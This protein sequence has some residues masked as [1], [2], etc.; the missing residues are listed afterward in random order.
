MLENFAVR[1]GARK[2]MLSS[3]WLSINALPKLKTA[4]VKAEGSFGLSGN[5]TAEMFN[6]HVGGFTDLISKVRGSG[7]PIV[8]TINA[9]MAQSPLQRD[10]L[11]E[12]VTGYKTTGTLVSLFSQL[13]RTGS[14]RTGE[15]K[16]A[17][18]NH[19]RVVKVAEMQH[20]MQL[21]HYSVMDTGEHNDE[22]KKKN[23]ELGDKLAILLG[24]FFWALA[25]KEIADTQ[26]TTGHGSFAAMR[27][28][29][30]FVLPQVSSRKPCPCFMSTYVCLVVLPCPGACIESFRACI[31]SFRALL[32]LLSGDVEK[33]A[34]PMSKQQEDEILAL[35]QTVAKL[36]SSLAL[37]QQQVNLLTQKNIESKKS[38]SAL[39]ERVNNLTSELDLLKQKQIGSVTPTKPQLTTA[40]NELSQLKT[41][42][43]D[44]EGRSRRN[45]L[46]FFGVTDT[47]KETWAQSE[48][49]I[50]G[51]CSRNIGVNIE[52]S[53]IERAHRLGAFNPQKCRPIIAKFS[54]FKDKEGILLSAFKLKRTVVAI[55]E[56]FLIS[57]RLARRHLLDFAKPKGTTY[58]PRHDKLFSDNKCYVYDTAL[59]AVKEKT[60]Y[61]G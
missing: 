5:F 51:L 15:S 24:D 57:F 44:P 58:K 13:K 56:D 2:L 45:N 14:V 27:W 30:F 12:H 18:A 47:D 37:L 4:L 53:K 49:L 36:Q 21:L 19:E 41:R 60:S 23:W 34:G 6:L 35:V 46:L 20:V 59:G 40:L 32:L 50:T 52:S 61:R 22:A 8:S 43:D 3:S 42:C 39:E 17:R 54:S 7:H 28:L 33:N 16:S 48:D 29:M 31:E 10:A 55:S 38:P 25:F 9:L 26:D 11:S 1:H